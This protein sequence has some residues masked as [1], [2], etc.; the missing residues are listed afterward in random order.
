MFKENGINNDFAESFP[1]FMLPEMNWFQKIVAP[2]VCW[3]RE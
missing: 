2:K 3:D 1:M